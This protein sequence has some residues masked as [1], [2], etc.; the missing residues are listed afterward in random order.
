GDAARLGIADEQT[1]DVTVGDTT[2]T[3]PAV[4]M[5]GQADGVISATWGQG[6]VAAGRIGTGVGART[7]GLGSHPFARVLSGAKN[8]ESPHTILFRSLQAH[9]RLNGPAEELF[10][11]TT[12]AELSHPHSAEPKAPPPSLLNIPPRGEYAW[13][14]VVDT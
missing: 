4:I 3:A 1:V 7:C 13:A 12:V 11:I 5:Q 6:R 8:A 2:I 14:M 9:T 10:K